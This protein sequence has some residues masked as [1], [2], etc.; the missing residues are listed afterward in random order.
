MYNGTIWKQNVTKFISG[1]R[2]CFCICLSTFD[3][4]IGPQFHL[5]LHVYTLSC[6]ISCFLFFLFSKCTNEFMF[7]YVSIVDDVYPR[8]RTKILCYPLF[9]PT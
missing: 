2:K 1:K 3:L 9:F 7:I 6:T 8:M 4:N 5:L